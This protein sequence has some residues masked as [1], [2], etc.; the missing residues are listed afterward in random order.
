MKLK[1]NL[2][3]QPWQ[4]PPEGRREVDSFCWI[5]RRPDTSTSS[6]SP[7]FSCCLQWGEQGAT[8]TQRG[9]NPEPEAECRAGPGAAT[10]RQGGGGGTRGWRRRTGGGRGG[11]RWKRR[12]GRGG[13]GERGGGKIEAKEFQSW[14][15]VILGPCCV[16]SWTQRF[17]T[18]LIQKRRK[19]VYLLWFFFKRM[20]W[21]CWI[22]DCKHASLGSSSDRF[23]EPTVIKTRRL[24][25]FDRNTL[26]SM[27]IF[28][29]Q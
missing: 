19:S 4:L 14:C 8:D 12:R 25:S 26:I 27:H 21:I 22:N 6:L 2:S 16:T 1:T 23:R 10:G 11:E 3:L 13:N 17:L 9:S 5:T 18:S 28:L 7:S 29:F 24:N 20:K 15:E